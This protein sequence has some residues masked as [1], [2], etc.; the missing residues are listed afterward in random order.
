[1]RARLALL[2]LCAFALPMMGAAGGTADAGGPPP[3]AI[4]QSPLIPI[5][6]VVSDLLPDP[7]RPVVYVA[8]QD[9]DRVLFIRTPKGTI[10]ADVPVG[11]TPRS[12]ALDPDGTL[13][14]VA[15]DAQNTIGVIDIAARQRIAGIPVG[16]RPLSIAAGR[17]GRLY[18]ITITYPPGWSP[19]GDL[20]IFDTTTW[21]MFGPFFPDGFYRGLAAMSRDDNTLYVLLRGLSPG[22]LDAIDVSTD[23]P[24]VTGAIY[25]A[26]NGR[27]LWVNWRGDTL[28]VGSPVST[29]L[30]QLPSLTYL[31]TVPQ[32]TTTAT[33]SPDDATLISS[34]DSDPNIYLWQADTLASLGSFPTPGGS[35]ILRMSSYNG[36]LAANPDIYNVQFYWPRRK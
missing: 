28:C 12:L 20:R 31:A 36:V 35:S 26:S 30:Y 7:N 6:G 14:Y 25:T 32:G 18:V 22:Y 13:L 19:L 33:T 8:D 16:A 23:T 29:D 15:E 9:N 24:V 17:P 11:D 10:L 21:T 34:H 3:S 1:M 2:L 27:D 4:R 5:G